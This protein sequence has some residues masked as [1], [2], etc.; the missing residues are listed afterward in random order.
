[1][2]DNTDTRISP[3]LHPD[4]SAVIDDYDEETRPVL[5][6]TETAVSMAFEALKSIHDAKAA[7]KTN[8]TLNDFAQ[9]VQVDDFA[10]KRMAPVM[11]TWDRAIDALNNNV[12]ALEK[13]LNGP[14]KARADS[15]IAVEV[16]AAIKGLDMGERM[17]A[18]QKAIRDGDEAVA[19]AVLGAPAM[20]SGIDPELQDSYRREWH[21]KQK[22]LEAKRVRAM[23]QAADLLNGRVKI[24]KKEWTE[25]VGVHEETKED[26]QGRKI[27]TKTWTPEQIR[28]MVRK[29][30]LPFAVPVGR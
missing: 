26:R 4:V 24:L 6:Q 11:Q 16:R 30:N 5:G 17:A 21:E 13:E 23:K 8:P 15:P 28:E 9:L 29:A 2:A 25:A 14:V 10:T 22:P 12:V 18:I 19:T 3:T 20:L 27:V 1:M 7:A